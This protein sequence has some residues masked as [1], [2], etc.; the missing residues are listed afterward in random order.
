[1]VKEFYF[2]GKKLDEL[3][4]M[5]LEDFT[6]LLPTRKR[7]TI[8]RGF[9]EA[10]KILLK[11]IDE[12]ISGKRKKPIRTH[13]RDMIILPKMVN[14]LIHVHNG[15]SFVVVQ[16]PKESLGMRLGELILTRSR[17]QHS[18]PGVGATKSSSAISVR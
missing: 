11:K 5:E 18:A 6:K 14:M 8:K 4:K 10:Q 1:M 13:C 7:R 17:V 16:I 3:K 2:K 12:T 15:K 9:T